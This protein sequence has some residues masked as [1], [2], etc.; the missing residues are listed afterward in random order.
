MIGGALRLRSHVALRCAVGFSLGALLLF[1]I[2]CKQKSTES[3]AADGINEKRLPLPSIAGL[4]PLDAALDEKRQKEVW[5]A[6]HATHLIEHRLGVR[7]R[8]LLG[9]R[10]PDLARLFAEDATFQTMDWQQASA[11]NVSSIRSLKT[12]PEAK[13]TSATRDEMISWLFDLHSTSS[14]ESKYAFRVLAIQAAEEQPN[15]WQAKM[16]LK[17]QSKQ[18]SAKKLIESK[19]SVTFRW[20]DVDELETSPAIQ[21]WQV[22]SVL[23]L[24]HI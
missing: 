22:D 12:K 18:S 13:K 6:E 4:A 21:G 8:E 11:T 2:G 7:F 19:H 1:S 20:N 14:S 16:L 24:I 9:S 5:D 15:T 3:T 10:S 23:S 17:S